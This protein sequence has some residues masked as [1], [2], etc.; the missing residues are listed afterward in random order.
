MTAAR[1]QIVNAPDGLAHTKDTVRRMAKLARKASH[2]YA[3]RS[4]ATR[5]VHDVPSKDRRGELAAIYRWVR[6]SIRYRFDPRGLEWLQA[7][8]RTIAERAGD[9]DDLATL[10][11]ALV[12]SLG[13]LARFRTVGASPQRQSHVSVQA[14]DGREWIDLDPV[15]E[16]P[17]PTTAPRAEL[18]AFGH[19]APG[20]ERLYDSKGSPMGATPPSDL[21][22]RLT[23]ERPLLPKPRVVRVYRSQ[24]SPGKPTPINL[25]TWVNPLDPS[26]LAGLPAGAQPMGFGIL[27][28]IGSAI[29]GGVKAIRAVRKKKK[30]KAK[31]AKA[32]KKRKAEAKADAKASGGYEPNGADGLA[33]A[34]HEAASIAREGLRALQ[35]SQSE[36][37][38]AIQSIAGQV[39]QRAPVPAGGRVLIPRSDKAARAPRARAKAR[40]TA[41][42]RTAVKR[43][44]GP[45]HAR[46]D[47]KTKR[48][49]VKPSGAVS[50]VHPLVSV[51]GRGRPALSFALGAVAVAGPG[52]DPATARRLAPA[53]ASNVVQRKYNYDRKLAKQ[54]QT[55]A[56]LDADG[57]YGGSSVGALRYFGIANPPRALFK[58]LAEQPYA[59]PS[60][61]AAPAPAPV[62]AP[63]PAP[64]P[65]ATRATT[66]TPYTPKPTTAAAAPSRR[67]LAQRAVD[68]VRAFARTHGGR[69]P[70]VPLP[71]VDKYQA[72]AG[73]QRGG[74]WG[75]AT[76]AA[77]ARDLGVKVSSLPP[78]GVRTRAPGPVPPTPGP[79]VPPP[80]PEPGPGPG[81]IVII[82][83]PSPEP[84]PV[85][86]PVAAECPDRKWLMWA[87]LGYLYMRGRRRAA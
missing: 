85:P 54:F 23:Y 75:D 16:Q 71:A 69:S 38:H 21:W 63:A 55:A 48:W 67:Q 70:A 7:P 80:P 76:R 47:A 33:P 29:G 1:V 31:K 4:L 72:A 66:T 60:S 83:P 59:P 30:A 9:C 11:A 19:R 3:I 5:I 18:G 61:A 32:A 22:P 35:A 51:A 13:H 73:L 14:F 36:A 25:S 56:G 79:F 86:V 58:P 44:A 82:D 24:G 37:I 53:L 78:A 15:V 26:D 62:V 68:A 45:T 39:V 43:G 34:L 50:G 20:F 74:L 41:K 42:H 12:Q 28:A 49:I 84:V 40:A 6:D 65:S 57:A 81:P 10:I 46:W 17:Q 64:S 77:A 87:G 8:E 27:T 2:S 52:Y